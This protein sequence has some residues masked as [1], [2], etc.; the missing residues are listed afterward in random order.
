[1]NDLQ[2]QQ[3]QGP[4]MQSGPLP[5]Q[6]N[7]T[8]TFV[9]SQNLSHQPVKMLTLGIKNRKINKGKN[10]NFERTTQVIEESKE[11]IKSKCDRVASF[12]LR[13]IIMNIFRINYYWIR[14]ILM[15]LACPLQISLKV[16]QL[17]NR[18][19]CRKEKAQS[20]QQPRKY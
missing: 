8:R 6:L 11:E 5:L 15:I 4:E 14:L 16:I 9:V 12:I 18:K 13:D 19:C 17:V 7:P 10:V 3:S 1:M 20:L 2:T